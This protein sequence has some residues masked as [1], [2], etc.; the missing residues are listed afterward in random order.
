MH[1]RTIFFSILG[2]ALPI[3]TQP[4]DPAPPIY[5]PASELPP[6]TQLDEDSVATALGYV[7]MLVQT[8]AGYLGQ[9]L[10]YPVTCAGSRSAIKDPI[11]VI[12][13]PIRV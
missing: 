12:Q 7:A 5:L 3:P 2:V 10:P 6:G 8:L 13:G 1:H 4:K 11:S 9:V